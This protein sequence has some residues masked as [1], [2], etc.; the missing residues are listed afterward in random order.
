MNKKQIIEK[1]KYVLT[2]KNKRLK[3]TKNGID[4]TDSLFWG[5]KGQSCFD[6]VR[7]EIWENVVLGGGYDKVTINATRRR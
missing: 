6:S 1:V 3:I 4:I 7:N 2:T 5:Q